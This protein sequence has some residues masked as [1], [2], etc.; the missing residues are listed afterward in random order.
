MSQPL[1]P[2]DRTRVTLR[3][4]SEIRADGCDAA[5]PRSPTSY[6]VSPAQDKRMTTCHFACNGL[7]PADDHHLPV[8]SYD[9]KTTWQSV[10]F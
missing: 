6:T 8:E 9:H 3:F 7:F 10:E 1:H 2:F 4:P 5:R